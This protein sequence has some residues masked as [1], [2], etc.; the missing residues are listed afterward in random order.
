MKS[1]NINMPL[2]AFICTPVCIFMFPT[3]CFSLKLGPS[4][5]QDILVNIKE[6]VK[7][8]RDITS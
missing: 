3:H 8:G 4:K 5:F 1:D 2:S 6:P 7:E